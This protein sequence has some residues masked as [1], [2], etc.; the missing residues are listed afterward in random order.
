MTVY[1]VVAASMFTIN[2]ASAQIS[3]LAKTN[4]V[5]VAYVPT[6]LSVKFSF[7]VDTLKLLMA[8]NNLVLE[9]MTYR[10]SN[11][12]LFIKKQSGNSS[13][14]TNQEGIYR[15][16]VKEKLLTI[17]PIS[18]PCADRISAFSTAG[19]IRADD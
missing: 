11:D 6:E 7:G 17:V 9:T 3:A 10:L 18:D 5:G 2:K 12:T 1:L 16:A 13:C 19:Y 15:V 4:W 14:D 8:D